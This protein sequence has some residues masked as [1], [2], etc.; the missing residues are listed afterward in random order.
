[1]IVESEFVCVCVGAMDGVSVTHNKYSA[2]CFMTGRQ[3]R[4]PFDDDY[5]IKRRC[6]CSSLLLNVIESQTD[7]IKSHCNP[8][9][10]LM[11]DVSY[12][13]THTTSNKRF[14]FIDARKAVFVVV[15]GVVGG[16]DLSSNLRVYS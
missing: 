8:R 3:R 14:N 16:C 1:M 15:V 6:R 10:N 13:A 12:R 9:H 5:E 11:R 4:R 7:T 2:W